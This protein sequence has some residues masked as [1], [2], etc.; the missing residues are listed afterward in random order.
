MRRALLGLACLLWLGAVPA[1]GETPRKVKTVL[2]FSKELNLGTEQRAQISQALGDLRDQM[3]SCQQKNLAL[4]KALSQL[5][6][7]HAPLPEIRKKFEEISAN[8]VDAK[9]A[10]VITARKIQDVLTPEQFENW[11]AIQVKQGAP[12]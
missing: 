6:R 2:S 1:L 11:K 12:P 8:E 10:D 5:L 7:N 3:L 9:M 4:Q